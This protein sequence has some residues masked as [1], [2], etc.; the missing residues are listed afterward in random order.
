MTTRVESTPEL[1]FVW[2]GETVPDWARLSLD[3]AGRTSGLP[4]VLI[5][6][7]EVGVVHGIKRQVWLEDFYMPPEDKWAEK[8]GIKLGFRNGFWR[9]AFERFIVLEQYVASHGIVSL[10]H[11]EVDNLVF[12]IGDLARHLDAVGRG[13]FCPRD[14]VSRG[15]ASLVYVNDTRTLTRMV[16]A[17]FADDL[18]LSSD[19]QLLGHMLQH[20]GMFYA[21][22]TERVMCAE[23]SREWETVPVDHTKGIFDASAVGQFMFGIDPRNGGIVLRNG[24]LNECRGCDLWGLH[25]ELDVDAGTCSLSKK[26]ER[27]CEVRLYN[28]HVHSKLFKAIADPV[29]RGRIVGRLNNGLTTLLAVRLVQWRPIRAVLSRLNL[30]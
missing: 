23:P 22:P 27:E 19:M 9:K 14:A 7:R 15:I 5:C 29:Q 12:R 21:L 11:A 4:T 6:S 2:L 20:D 1:V 18:P 24:F 16:N 13:L 3:I 25:I 10:F 30:E 26:T 8:K 28:I 17:F